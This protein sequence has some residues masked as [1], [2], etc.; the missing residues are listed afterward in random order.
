[1]GGSF[2]VFTKKKRRRTDDEKRNLN[3]QNLQ[4]SLL[5]L[6]LFY[7]QQQ[8]TK[9]KHTK[10]IDLLSRSIKSALSRLKV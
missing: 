8:Q 6:N 2:F 9:P 7:T 4:I 3:L 1:M 10:R 5:S